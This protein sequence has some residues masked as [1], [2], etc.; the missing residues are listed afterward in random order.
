M[1][2]DRPVWMNASCSS[3]IGQTDKKSSSVYPAHLS[4]PSCFFNGIVIPCAMAHEI[5]HVRAARI[6]DAGA[7][8]FI[9]RIQPRDRLKTGGFREKRHRDSP[10]SFD[11]SLKIWNKF[12]LRTISDRADSPFFSNHFFQMVIM[13]LLSS[14]PPAC[15]LS[16]FFLFR[17]ITAAG[18]LALNAVPAAAG[19]GIYWEAETVS[20]GMPQNMPGR[21]PPDVLADLKD[22]F[23][24][25]DLVRN[26]LTSAAFRSESAA[27]ITVID[28][29]SREILSLDPLRKIATRIQM[30]DM[31]L[32]REPGDTPGLQAAATGKTREIAGYPCR[33]YTVR[34]LSTQGVYWVSEAV[35]GYDRMLIFARRLQ[36]MTADNPLLARLDFAGMMNLMNGF[37]VQTIMTSNGIKTVTTLKSIEEKDLADALFKIPEGYRVVEMKDMMPGETPPSP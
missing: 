8:A 10:H 36:E 34:M 14:L 26:F 6:P 20:S 12:G 37:P 7:D 2:G 24:R 18:V 15:R 21:L 29:H 17:V 3:I 35:R 25:T 13:N 1:E 16:F 28:F 11:F 31:P 22:R 9:G 5:S 19:S 23:N 30:A 32:V 27:G 33:E 4:D